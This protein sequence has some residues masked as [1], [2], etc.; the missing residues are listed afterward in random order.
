MKKHRYLI[1]VMLCL[2]L[3]LLQAETSNG[4]KQAG[5]SKLEAIST[6]LH[7][8]PEQKEK[9]LPILAEEGPKVEAV[10]NDKSLSNMQK[11]QQMRAI[12]QQSDPQMK[13]I[14]SPAQY[15][16]LQNIRRQ[17]IEQAIQKKRGH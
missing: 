8:T 16:Q 7:L 12:H 10:K 2:G 5:L 3:F 17:A 9:V 4:Q 1:A 6:Q 11:M 15:Q 14:L 13:A